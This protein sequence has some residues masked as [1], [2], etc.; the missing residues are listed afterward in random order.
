M[1]GRW[2]SCWAGGGCAMTEQM[3]VVTLGPAA[4]HAACRD[5]LERAAR[6]GLPDIV[7]GIRSG[8]MHV[9]QA[10]AACLPVSTKVLGITCRRPG[11]AAKQRM[12]LFTKVLRRLPPLVTDRLRVIEHHMQRRRPRRV[13]AVRL[14]QVELMGIA[15]AMACHPAGRLLVVDDAVDSGATLA[16]VLAGLAQIAPPELD[17]TSAAITVTM[18][19]PVVL[20]D[21]ALHR[22]ALCRFPWSFD[23]RETMDQRA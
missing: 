17:I 23:A 19:D 22:F 1:L 6:D 16:C 21:H 11:T 7:V 8:G 20:P 4:F 14:D 12:P 9:A 10:M 2:G 13:A 15:A 18:P 3:R 5:L